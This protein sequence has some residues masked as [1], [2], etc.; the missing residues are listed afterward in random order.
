MEWANMADPPPVGTEAYR[1]WAAGAQAEADARR[2]GY[3]VAGLEILDI[4]DSLA[5]RDGLDGV[6][7]AEYIFRIHTS[8]LPL[9][10][11]FVLAWKTIRR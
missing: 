2:E 3:T 9:R 8:H 5:R 11:R 4:M 1:W 7:I 10:R 6:D